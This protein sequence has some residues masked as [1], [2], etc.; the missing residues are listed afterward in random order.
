MN[1]TWKGIA[2][3]LAI[4][5]VAGVLI[6]PRYGA[7]R[8]KIGRL[9]GRKEGMITVIEFLAD[10]FPKPDGRPIAPGHHLGLKWY[11]INVI[12]TNGITTLQVKNDM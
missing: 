6:V 2:I 4:A 8:E 10:H 7:W 12:Q 3:G 9:D 11:T 5:A 1:Q